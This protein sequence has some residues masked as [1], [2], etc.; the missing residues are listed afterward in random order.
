MGWFGRAWVGLAAG[1]LLAAGTGAFAGEKAAPSDVEKQ[2]KAQEEEKTE[3]AIPLEPVLVQGFVKEV[4][5]EQLTLTAPGAPADLPLTLDPETRFIQGESDMS[6]KDV[7]AGQLVRAALLPVG[8]DLIALV[9]EVV[10]EE[11]EPTVPGADQGAPGSDSDGAAA[12]PT[13]SP[14]PASPAPEDGPAQ[15][16]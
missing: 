7:E 15:R 4:N 14:A 9:V 12:E 5:E 3:R 11:P 13:P 1:A 10:P 2:G 6:R 8:R 16:L